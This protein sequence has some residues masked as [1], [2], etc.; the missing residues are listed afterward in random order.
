MP[1]EDS[2]RSQS[3]S[4]P[5]RRDD[6]SGASSREKPAA[7]ACRAEVAGAVGGALGRRTGSNMA[8]RSSSGS[9]AGSPPGKEWGPAGLQGG[10][11]C[12]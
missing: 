7:I 1:R 6:R 11:T 10:R 2:W 9:G 12:M 8:S 5:C 3:G 4:L